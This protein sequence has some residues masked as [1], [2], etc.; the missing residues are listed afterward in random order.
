MIEK[1]KSYFNYALAA[2]IAIL[3]FLYTWEKSKRKQAEALNLNIETKEQ[4]NQL[5]KEIYKNDAAL[6]A[7]ETKRKEIN[8][9]FNKE[10]SRE[11]DTKETEDFFNNRKS[12]N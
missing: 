12:D 6:Q 3:G 7:E 9:D 1:I 8:E 2:G 11:L 5:N 10:V 4:I